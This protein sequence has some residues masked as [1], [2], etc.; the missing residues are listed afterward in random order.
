MKN[1]KKIV[2]IAG[3]V[4][5]FLLIVLPAAVFSIVNWGILPPK[6][7][8][9]I[10]EREVNKMLKGHLECGKI[11]LT[12]FETYP[13]LGI[14]IVDGR[15][16]SN[17][18]PDSLATDSL[19]RFKQVTATIRPWDYLL[20]GQITIGEVILEEPDFYGYVS[21]EGKANWD[22]YI[23]ETDSTA[24]ADSTS[25]LP[26]FD[27]QK[28][29]IDGGHFIYDDRQGE[30]YAE[31]KGFFLRLAGSL[32]QEGNKFDIE[33]GSSSILYQSP[34]YTLKNEMSLRLKS[35]LELKD[36]FNVITLDNAEMYA[37]NIPFRADGS[38]TNI[39]DR[40]CL[41]LNLEFGLEAS[42]MNDLLQFI[43]E[44]YFKDMKAL[45]AKGSISLKGK[46]TGELAEDLMPTVSLCCIVDG[47]SFHMK[48]VR[49]G[50]DSLNMDMDLYLD[51]TNPNV[52]YV[53]LEKLKMEGLNTS[54]D[55]HGK[56]TNLLQSPDIDATV[57]GKID[58]TSLAKEFLHPDTFLVQGQVNAD[59]RAAFAMNDLV[60]GKYNK[61]NATGKLNIDTLIACSPAYGLD[62]FI[63]NVRFLVDSTS[64]TSRFIKGDKLLNAE[65]N[66]DSVNIAYKDRINTN[67]SKFSM[68]AKTSPEIDT[69]AV[70]SVT[71]HI[72][73]GYLRARLPDST[74]LLAQNAYLAGGIR[75]SA[76]NKKIPNFAASI[77]ADTLRY[78]A[79]PLR[80]GG[81]MAKGRF[82]VEALPIRDAM[83]QRRQALHRDST[84][85]AARDT[86]LRRQR[87]NTGNTRARAAS[88]DSASSVN[89]LRNWEVRGS[90]SFNQVR[91]FS[92]M[93]PLPMRVE[94]TKVKF[95][96]NN[97]TFSDARFHVGKS[98]FTLTGDLSSMRR[99][100][101][102]GG[103]LKGEFAV[104]SDYIDCNELLQTMTRGLQYMSR[105][106]HAALPADSL[107]EADITTIQS[108]LAE[109]TADTTEQL[110]I[111]PKF[112]DMSLT[113]DAKKVDYKDMEMK[114]VV[115]EVVMRNQ[116][117]NLRRL[118]MKSN[119]GDGSWTMFY[120]AKDSTG[121]S[122]GVDMEM[123]GIL[124][125]KLLDLYP[126]IDTLLPMLRSF[127]GIM[128]CQMSMACN[129]DSTM[130][131]I[132]PSINMACFLRGKN[133]VLLD[134]ETFAEISKTLMFK[135]KKQNMIDSISVDLAIKDNK[136]EIFPFLV[137]MDRYKVAVGGEHNLD[138]TF[139]YHISVLKSP[140]PFKLGIDIT[141]NLDDFKYKITKCKYKNTFDPAR[142]Q[143]LIATKVNLRENIREMVRKEIIANAPELAAHP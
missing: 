43:P 8:T 109:E 85:V 15:L 66:I 33:T 97:I 93:F 19:L 56:V 61:I 101:L 91:I 77:T 117:L 20:K 31:V 1:K 120:S 32:I 50:I 123:K 35:K 137:E 92:R 63:H 110:F 130:S 21:P 68:T 27:L 96:T 89:M 34:S 41:A 62:V 121:A 53:K 13:H 37:N 136:I 74:W 40:K 51:G 82:A 138:M 81:L 88:A 142:E 105:R 70:I 75:P 131:F 11:E 58:F 80:T 69:T 104:G 72:K 100:M 42:D 134:G 44:S 39:P 14:K 9:P 28:V 45:Q 79:I 132:L 127:Q 29:K 38:V 140:V 83:Q 18:L 118:Q 103:K 98:N 5:A 102:R 26:P 60:E 73:A 122:A 46:V 133:M 24:E 124:V 7:L 143:E 10:V 25:A 108:S 84:A 54:L 95:D 16:I 114:D 6:K 76:S 135:N 107:M 59:I 57:K 65:L 94:E 23:S 3:L 64:V 47:G 112:L 116:S 129:L 17:A 78:F 86:T 48:D 125:D 67:I 113:L 71:S 141:G 52:S 87:Q 49:Q 119:I 111:V 90:A 126:A 22:I 30:T 2:L 106:E 128:D 4:L 139:N 12:F 36:N 55:A 115:G 99:A